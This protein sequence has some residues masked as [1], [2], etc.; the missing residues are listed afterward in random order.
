M[1]AI[2]L[3]AANTWLTIIQDGM[4]AKITMEKEDTKQKLS[5]TASVDDLLEVRYALTEMIKDMGIDDVNDDSNKKASS[6]EFASSILEDI[7][8]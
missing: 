3:K 6:D 1:R 5:L 2:T 8:K 7:I 4:T